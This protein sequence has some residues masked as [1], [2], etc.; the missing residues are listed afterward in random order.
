MQSTEPKRADFRHAVFRHTIDLRV[1]WAEVD[2]QRVV[3][4]GHYLTYCDICITEYWR[5]IGLEYPQALHALG[6]DTFVRKATLEYFDAAVFDDEL[7]IA[8]RTA[9]L[10]RTSLRFVIEMTR[11]RAP[12]AVL[13][14]AELVYVNASLSTRTPV[15]WP[16]GVREKIRAFEILAPEEAARGA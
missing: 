9:A 5:A 10:G 7:R 8:G 12:D 14:G 6:C 15:P 16:D 3:F 13:I 2:A 11:Q 1:R 4:N